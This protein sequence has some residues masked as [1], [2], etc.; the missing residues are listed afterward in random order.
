MLRGM[1]DSFF[2]D[3]LTVI[4]FRSS[5]YSQWDFKLNTMKRTKT[6]ASIFPVEIM[7]INEGS[8]CSTANL[9]CT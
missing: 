3:I 8:F 2:L 9:S 5:H 4:K 1:K 6:T 7:K